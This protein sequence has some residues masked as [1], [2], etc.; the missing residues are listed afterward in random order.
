MVYAPSAILFSWGN[1]PGECNWVS[2]PVGFWI[3]PLCYLLSL[4]FATTACGRFSQW[5][6]SLFPVVIHSTGTIIG[7]WIVTQH[8]EHGADATVR[9]MVASYVEATTLATGYLVTDWL[10]A[11]KD[12]KYRSSLILTH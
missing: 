9:F 1:L 5:I 6:I 4:M 3:I 8:A 7:L 2:K 12:L 11:R 10:L